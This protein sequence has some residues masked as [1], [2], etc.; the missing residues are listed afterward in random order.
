[1]QNG[2]LPDNPSSNARKIEISMGE[3]TV[4]NIVTKDVEMP[5]A[6]RVY[7]YACT[8]ATQGG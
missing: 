4:V 6:L 1:M 5:P 2:R 8:E 7:I 3:R